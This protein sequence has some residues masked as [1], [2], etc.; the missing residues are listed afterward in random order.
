[1]NA[2]LRR[3]LA[4]LQ[5]DRRR[6]LLAV[7]AGTAALGCA[8]GLTAVSA[9]LI[10]RASQHPPVLALQVAVVATRAFGIGRGV[11]RY[12]ERLAAHDVALRGV[13]T[14]RERLYRSLAAAD[15]ALVAGLRRGDLLARV[16]AD[17]DTLADTVARALLPFGVG[18][19][20]ATGTVV[21]LTALLPE[22]GA[23]VAAGLLVAGGLAPWLAARGC[24]RAERD[25]ARIRNAT[26]AEVLGILDGLP[27]LTVAGAV[28]EH[29]ARVREL[30]RRL[31]AAL[32]TAAR[33]SALAAGL[34]TLATTGAALA[35]LALGLR[36]LQ[37]GAIG[38]AVLAV[39]ALTPLAAAE[40]VTGLP[41]AAVTMVR[42]RAAARRV[43]DLLEASPAAQLPAAQLPVAQV[44]AGPVRLQAAGLD[45]GRRSGS[46]VLSNVDLDLPPGTKLA[47]VGP[48]GSGKTT[49]LLTLA[50][51]LPPL[52]GTLTP[53][54]GALRQLV[55]FT[56]EDAHLFATTL[57]EN[58]RVA[59]PGATDG[60]L[61]DALA[62]VRLAG[63]LA[64]L[65]GGL[66]TRLASGGTDVSGGERRRL[67]LARALLSGAAVLLI[68]EPAEHLDPATAEA[69]VRDLLSIPGRT[70]VLATHRHEGLDAADAVLGVEHLSRPHAGA[71][72]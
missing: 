14:V 1:M 23:A 18:L 39:V 21:L 71:G 68:D 17:V 63:W 6:V 54:P 67:L 13:V 29:L 20:T 15:P 24:A 51:L 43:L 65:P 5:V 69:L 3:A 11:L 34:G 7:L 19:L 25:A 35:C 46:P 41:A 42:A 38:P 37:A 72:R 9:W 31:A 30:D 70:V 44:P 66:D 61:L 28:P 57:R 45:V 33:G 22:A 2:P 59:R 4:A 53:A 62:Q 10:V 27:E 36:A 48:S 58:L 8:I 16:G 55:R 40:A 52:A 64:S 26:S 32:E 49:L 60:E 50:G 12:V 56:A 47:L